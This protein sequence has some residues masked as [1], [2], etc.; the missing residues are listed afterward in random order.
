[1]EGPEQA[2]D[3]MRFTAEEKVNQKYVQNIKLE[4]EEQIIECVNKL[5]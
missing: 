4:T 3:P 1:M 5:K 2:V